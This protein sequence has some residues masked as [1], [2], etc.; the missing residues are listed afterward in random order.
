MDRVRP[1]QVTYSSSCLTSW[2]TISSIA[3][4]ATFDSNHK[5]LKEDPYLQSEMC[6]RL[7]E[8]CIGRLVKFWLSP[9]LGMEHMES[10]LNLTSLEWHMVWLTQKPGVSVILRWYLCL[11][12]SCNHQVCFLE[13]CS[14]HHWHRRVMAPS[15][16][17]GGCLPQFLQHPPQMK[18]LSLKIFATSIWRWKRTHGNIGER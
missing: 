17:P 2:K 18:A 6:V 3:L 5:S 12:W 16:Y 14:P 13:S 11:D 4:R 10:P 15:F 9:L 8:E 7:A 1:G